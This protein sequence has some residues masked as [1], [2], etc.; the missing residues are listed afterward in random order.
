MKAFKQ[1][2]RLARWIPPGQA[3]TPKLEAA[4]PIPTITP[5]EKKRRRLIENIEADLKVAELW[6]E[7]WTTL[8]A[9]LQTDPSLWGQ[10]SEWSEEEWELIQPE[11]TAG[12]LPAFS[13]STR[14]VALDHI[15]QARRRAERK[16]AGA[17]ARLEKVQR[18]E[19]KPL[20]KTQTPAST[21]VEKDVPQR[22]RK[23]PGI[24]VEV[25]EGLW[26]RIGRSASE[27]D[28]LF[29]QARDRDLWF[30]VRG[31]AGAHVWVPRGQPGFGAKSEASSDLIYYGCQLALLNSSASKTGHAVVDFTER[32]HLR[33]IRSAV[34]A[35]EILRSETK[36]VRTD[37]AFERKILKKET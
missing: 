9:R 3:A 7:R 31:G 16:Q 21:T 4:N 35:V 11:I 6:L 5:E 2:L 28:E 17:R 33:K 20:L 12:K 22:P 15:F 10:R 23:K 37:E 36:A 1:S 18:Q 32:R 26:A 27:N 8:C 25:M 24:W 34:G 13:A 19:V 14:G 29:R 30:H